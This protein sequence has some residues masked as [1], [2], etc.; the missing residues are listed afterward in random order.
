MLIGNSEGLKAKTV[1]SVT[2]D[3]SW[4]EESS[5][6][7]T[8]ADYSSRGPSIG[9][10]S[11][12]PVSV[13][14]PDLVAPGGDIYTAA[15]RLDPNGDL[16]DASGYTTVDGNSFSAAMVA[17]AVA[18]VKQAHP[19]YTPAQLKS[20]VVNTA[21][22]NI[23]DDAGLARVHSAGAGKL[24]VQAAISQQIS[25]NPPSLA[26]SAGTTLPSATLTLTNAGTASQTLSLTVAQRDTDSRANITAPSSVT[27]PAGQTA[28]ITVS[29]TGS[30][31][32]PGSYEG[33]INLT[34]SG[35]SLHVPYN[36]LVTDG[37]PD[38]IFPVLGDSWYSVPGATGHVIA[39]R[40]IDQY[41]I[42]VPNLPV[43]WTVNQ[44]GGRIDSSNGIP[45]ADVQTDIY[46]TA[47]A[48]IDFGNQFGD[49][50]FTGLLGTYSWEF[51]LTAATFPI[52]SANGVVNG[53]SFQ[54]SPAAA[55][56][57]IT[58]NGQNLTHVAASYVTAGLPLAIAASSVSFDIPSAGISAPGHLSYISPTQINVQVPW[59]V[60]GNTQAQIKVITAGIASQL[61][62]LP[63]AEYGPAVFEYTGSDGRLYAAAL[64]A[65]SQLITIANPA[66]R[67]Q[68]I[69]LYANGLGPVANQPP[70]GTPSPASPLAQAASPGDI[71]VTIGGVPATVTFVGL[72]PN[73]VGLY[74]LNLV[75]PA[76]SASGV[77]PLVISGNN[78]GSKASLLAVSP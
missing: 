5:T 55:G 23:Q 76:A 20:A 25:V 21:T 64:D 40:V 70:S 56:S 15:Q 78:V 18:L 39:A 17:G 44:G 27:I 30:R 36:Y 14:K 71:S 45:N 74:Q 47:G 37:N 48:T 51:D 1:A 67:G 10:F 72:A 63:L 59:E 53:A 34:G 49:Q 61:Y 22:T 65:N 29:L 32:N 33:Q 68:Y 62:T 4:H 50:I 6:P 16:Y 38:N 9:V 19:T 73:Y 75:V 28:T 77:Q 57:Y 42:P 58:I 24:N 2:L 46:G 69:S 8:V 54:N 43:T 66:Q 35:V 26:F 11:S 3:P 52:I 13:V 41:G 12:T 7:D 60:Q 31:P